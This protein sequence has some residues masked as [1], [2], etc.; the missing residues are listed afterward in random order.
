MVIAFASDHGGYELKKSLMEYAEGIGYT[1]VD[2]GTHDKESCDYP[3]FGYMAAKSV[4]D[5]VSDAGV[6]VCTT[7]IGMSIVANKVKGVRCALCRDEKDAEMTRRHNNSNVLA[8]G[9]AATGEE[10]A[11]RIMSRFL[12]TE[13]EGGRHERRVDKISDIERKER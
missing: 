4:A 1:V 12:G 8:L 9:Q 6:V 11:K 2:Y 13:F 7:G 3:D 10:E 5:G